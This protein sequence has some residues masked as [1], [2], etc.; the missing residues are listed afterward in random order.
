MA[1]GLH[2]QGFLALRLYRILHF[3]LKGDENM[4]LKSFLA[5]LSLKVKIAVVCAAVAVT[6]T[7][8]AVVIANTSA[9]NTYRVLKVFE[10]SGS[11]V[12]SRQGAGDLDAYEP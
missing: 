11:A 1:V 10:L 9:D 6:G 2:L 5:S 8:T 4:G 12:V 7:A 3:I